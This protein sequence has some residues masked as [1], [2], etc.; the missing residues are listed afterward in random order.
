MLSLFAILKLVEVV[1][2][3]DILQIDIGRLKL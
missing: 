3:I 1:F 2:G